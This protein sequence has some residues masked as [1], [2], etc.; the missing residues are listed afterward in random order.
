MVGTRKRKPREI[1]EVLMVKEPLTDL[2]GL[3]TPGSIY[4][5][6]KGPSHLTQVNMNMDM[7]MNMDR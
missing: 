5:R 1:I 2:A 3:G 4:G 7:N 6:V